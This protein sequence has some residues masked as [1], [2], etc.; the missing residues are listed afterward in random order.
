MNFSF[1]CIAIG[2][3]LLLSTYNAGAKDYDCR[4][5][6]SMAASDRP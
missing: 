2:L 1:I 6:R 4:L 5:L 3:A